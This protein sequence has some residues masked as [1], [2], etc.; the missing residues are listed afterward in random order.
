[1]DKPTPY[2]AVFVLLYMKYKWLFFKFEFWGW[3]T[4]PTNPKSQHVK[5][6][7]KVWTKD[8]LF[9]FIQHIFSAFQLFV[10]KLKS[11]IL[12]FRDRLLVGFH[13]LFMVFDRPLMT[14]IVTSPVCTATDWLYKWFKKRTSSCF[15]LHVQ[16]WLRVWVDR[17]ALTWNL[18]EQMMQ[19]KSV[20][21]KS[22]V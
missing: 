3:L 12:T 15:C 6:K 18:L 5:K 16:Q 1:M 2:F 10:C 21:R 19:E 17:L 9:H 13:Q 22:V 8:V 14:G 11:N 20:D 7:K 4:I